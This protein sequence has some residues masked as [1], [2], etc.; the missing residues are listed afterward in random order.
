MTVVLDTSSLNYLIL[1][2]AEEILP[3][4]F[5]SIYIP[6]AV[7]DELIDPGASDSV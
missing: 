7:R 2:G 4:L 1:I 6:N 5:G 3:H